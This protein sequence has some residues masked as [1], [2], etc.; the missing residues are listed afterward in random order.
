VTVTGV[1]VAAASS[2]LLVAASILALHRRRRRRERREEARAVAAELVPE[3]QALVAGCD[4]HGPTGGTPPPAARYPLLRQRLPRI[5]SDPCLFAVET[6]YQSVE[7][8]R[9]ASSEMKEAFAE[10][11]DVSLGDRIRAKDRRDRCLKDVF[12]T[13]EAAVESLSKR[14]D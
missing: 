12:Y 5:V 10:G 1:V 14:L 4:L 6:F 8:Y 11:S 13:G 9:V 3:I 7:A 2:G